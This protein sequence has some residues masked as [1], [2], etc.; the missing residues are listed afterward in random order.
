MMK[1]LSGIIVVFMGLAPALQADGHEDLTKTFAYC[2]GRLSAEVEHAWLMGT[3]NVDRLERLRDGT[4]ALL[5]SVVDDPD[6]GRALE[7]RILA[8]HAHADLLRDAAFHP[9]PEVA[10][11]AGQMAS[12]RIGACSSFLLG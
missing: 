7:R 4:L 2:A 6:T 10:R 3:G 1:G 11:R 8:K 9:D 5:A 12:L